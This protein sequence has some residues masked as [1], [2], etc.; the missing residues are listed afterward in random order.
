LYRI[1]Q[2]L[3]NNSIKHA[4]CSEISIQLLSRDNVLVLTYSDNGKGFDKAQLR[5]KGFGLKNI[6]NRVQLI[7]GKINWDTSLGNGMSVTV[8]VPG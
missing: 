2:E 3:L 1:T 7:A 5:E 8:E 6:E 4:E